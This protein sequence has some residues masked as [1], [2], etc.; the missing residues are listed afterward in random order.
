M[1]PFLFSFKLDLLKAHVSSY[2]TIG[3]VFVAAHE[4][5]RPAKRQKPV[6]TRQGGLFVDSAPSS[7]A[8]PVKQIEAD[9]YAP[10]AQ[11]GANITGVDG[12]VGCLAEYFGRPEKEVV[13]LLKT[14]VADF[15]SGEKFQLTIKQ[16]KNA[17]VAVFEGS[18]G[19]SI[20]RAF[21]K[22]ASG[23]LFVEHFSF[24]SAHMGKGGGKAVLR[25][26]VGVYQKLG[27][28]RMTLNANG[29]VGGYV[30]ARFGFIPEDWEK[31]RSNLKN[32][33]DSIQSGNHR[34]QTRNKDG[35]GSASNITAKFSDDAF[36]KISEMLKSD[37]PSVIGDI[38]GLTG[39]SG[40]EIGKELLLGSLWSGELNLNDK[41]AMGVFNKYLQKA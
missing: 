37:D 17:V 20:W 38:A 10:K 31:V 40:R 27:V 5:K 13:D 14:M 1:N 41:R 23:K 25:C 11:V 39:T 33:L 35:T 4:D 29:D 36:M 15:G 26:S 12:D 21:R 30:W 18:D 3:G 22:D 34:N 28:D 6:S 24:D 2:T 32:I 16:K 7:P 8:V 9:L 19:S